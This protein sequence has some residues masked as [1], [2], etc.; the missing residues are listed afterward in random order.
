MTEKSA[1]IGLLALVRNTFRNKKSEFNEMLYGTVYPSVAVEK[2]SN[3]VAIE[4]LI[5]FGMDVKKIDVDGRNIIH[6]MVL[7]DKFSN[8]DAIDILI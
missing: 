8:T 5:E 1:D 6:R 2:N 7:S 4:K 3:T